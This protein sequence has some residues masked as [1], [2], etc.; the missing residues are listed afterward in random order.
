MLALIINDYQYK[1]IL[2]TN[3]IKVNENCK[4]G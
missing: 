4:H 2:F 3:I 1:I